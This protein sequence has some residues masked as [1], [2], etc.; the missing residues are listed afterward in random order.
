M[1]IF[2]PSLLQGQHMPPSPVVGSSQAPDAYQRVENPSVDYVSQGNG[3]TQP[4]DVSVPGGVR[5]LQ[6]SDRL[7]E[8]WQSTA[9]QGP[10]APP[11]YTQVENDHLRVNHGSLAPRA[12]LDDGELEGDPDITNAFVTANEVHNFTEDALGREL[13][14]RSHDGRLDINVG[15]GNPAIGPVHYTGQGRINLPTM[16][17]TNAG[18]DADTV[19]HEQ[20]HA[21][22][23]AARP[24]IATSPENTPAHEGFAD[25]TAL[26]ASLRNEDVRADTIARWERGEESGLAS[27]VGEAT[28][29]A[30]GNHEGHTEGI[31]D[32]AD[33]A[34]TGADA[35]LSGHDASRKFS[36][37]V[38]DTI[39]DTYDRLRA[40]NPDMS[41]DEALRRANDIV[42]RDLVRATDFIPAGTRLSQDDLARAMM[43]A[44]AVDHG[45]E[46]RDA[47]RENFTEAGLRPVTTESRLQ[48]AG[49]AEMGVELPENLR[50]VDGFERTSA[51]QNTPAMRSAEAFFEQNR[52]ALGAQEGVD[53]RAQRVYHNDRGETFITYS[54]G[55]ALTA[56][57]PLPSNG[58]AQNFMVVGFDAQGQL[59]H[60]D[61]A[62]EEAPRP[63]PLPGG[64]PIPRPGGGLPGPGSQ[65]GPGGPFP[66]PS[67]G[68]GGPP[69]PPPWNSGPDGGE[70]GSHHNHLG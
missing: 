31:R 14:Y 55:Q 28:A 58:G 65:P 69:S 56:P 37:G 44:N 68:N 63:V 20:G 62:Y 60:A 19:A 16:G 2:L 52:E 36:S 27:Q 45:G 25:A 61:S 48:E 30:F 43:R 35:E 59:I 26:V 64:F 50:G 70:V 67:W 5:V 29:Q 23:N 40:E 4:Q 11:L 15:H 9:G 42:G 7:H 39:H 46:L 1:A 53:Y 22:L 38:Y 12:R 51:D 66:F 13:R 49:L 47:Y 6:A 54:D 34:P 24:E 41:P 8:A 32:L 17:G 33:P 57:P 10:A 3:L 21:I 18:A